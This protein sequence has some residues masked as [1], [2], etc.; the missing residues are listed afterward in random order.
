[1][2]YEEINQNFNG[3][4]ANDIIRWALESFETPMISTKF[5]PYSATLLHMVTQIKP[6]ILVVW[7]DSGFNTRATYRFAEKVIQDF[8][9][10]IFTYTPKYTSERIK[11]RFNGIPSVGSEHHDVFS[12]IVK[13][14]PMKRA[15]EDLKPDCWFSGLRAQQS[16]YRESIGYVS[17]GPSGVSKISPLLKWSTKDLYEYNRSNNLEE[18]HDYFDPVKGHGNRECGIHL[19][20]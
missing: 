18:E 12:E 4:T 14:E 17:T 11:A 7:V 10:N 6:D 9:L 19:L 13:I 8:E 5:G 16:S 20:K 2:N 3:A 15:L 1:M